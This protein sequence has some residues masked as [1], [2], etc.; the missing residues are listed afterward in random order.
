MTKYEINRDQFIRMVESGDMN[1]T[2]PYL[3]W[4]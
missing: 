1:I 4:A 2:N 3:E